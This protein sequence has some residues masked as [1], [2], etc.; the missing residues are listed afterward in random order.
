MKQERQ[1]RFIEENRKLRQAILR[2]GDNAKLARESGVCRGTI[3]RITDKITKFPWFQTVH[4]LR[5]VLDRQF[6]LPPPIP[7]MKTQPV[8]SL[9]E[10]KR[11]KNK[12]DRKVIR[13]SARRRYKLV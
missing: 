4:A 6:V 9:R 1:P 2:Y 3:D 13:Q 8:R 11:V 7:V 10:R 12:P 5:L